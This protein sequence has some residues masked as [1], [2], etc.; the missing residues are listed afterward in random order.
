MNKKILL[1]LMVIGVV[2]AIVAG[3]TGAWWTDQAKSTNTSFHSGNMKLQ[4]AN[5]DANGNPA[6]G[7]HD[8]VSQTWDYDEMVPDGDPVGTSLWLRNS[9]ST[10]ADWLKI[11]ATTNPN[12]KDKDMDKHMRITQLAYAGESL[13]TGGAGADLSG[14]EEPVISDC[15]LIVDGDY[16][17]DSEYGS[18]Q[19]A[20]DVAV[21]GDLIC[22]RNGSY[23]ETVTIDQGVSLA[24]LHGQEAIIG[25]GVNVSSD[26]VTVKGFKILPTFAVGGGHLKGIYLGKYNHAVVEYNE[27]DGTSVTGITRGLVTETGATY[28]AVKVENNVIHDLTT[29]IYTNSHTGMIDI[30]YNDIYNT[31]AGIGGFTGA[32]AQFNRFY[33]NGEAIGAD[34]SYL[35]ATIELN[36][37]LGD[38]VNNYSSSVTVKAENNW[39]G[40]FDPSDQITGDVDYTPYL[41]GPVIGFIN[42]NDKNGNGF[43]DLNDLKRSTI[44]ITDPDLQV[45]GDNHHSLL[46]KTQLD[47][48]TAEN[49]DQGKKV[50][51]NVIIDMGQGP[52]PSSN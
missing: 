6:G 33:D 27:I 4:L 35:G 42:G 19:G 13:L 28:S 26:G 43:A 22:V 29:G 16:D 15:D 31:T 36:E 3:T 12:D 11:T 9:G 51:L 24:A 44:V 32:D 38:A 2:A 18:I 17:G 37:F 48:P 41:G 20:V 21:A 52:A 50:G 39:W 25:K 14:Y 10:P 8:N 23:N 5:S 47:G 1:S 34:D 45:K 30:K 49:N 40:D 7:W 46:L